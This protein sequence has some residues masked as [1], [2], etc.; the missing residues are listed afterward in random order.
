MP[1]HSPRQERYGLSLTTSA[2]LA[3]ERFIE[4]IDLLLEQNCG[5]EDQCTRLHKT[6]TIRYRYR[7]PKTVSQC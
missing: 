4:D 5:P 3:A 2:T 1:Y 7:S 6:C